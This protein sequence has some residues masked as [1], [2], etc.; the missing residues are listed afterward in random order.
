MIVPLSKKDN[1]EKTLVGMRV[2]FNVERNLNLTNPKDNSPTSFIF[3]QYVFFT[4]VFLEELLAKIETE[5]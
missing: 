1:E 3:P 2:E 5:K 4:P